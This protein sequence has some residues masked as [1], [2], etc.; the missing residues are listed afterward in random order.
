MGLGTNSAQLYE[1]VTA[2]GSS[3]RQDESTLLA[4]R[5]GVTAESLETSMGKPPE[6]RS[7]IGT[8]QRNIF[9]LDTAYVVAY[10]DG[11]DVVRVLGLISKNGA[12]IGPLDFPAGPVTLG[13]STIE[14]M[15]GPIIGEHSFTGACGARHAYMYRVVNNTPGAVN[16]R[17]FASGVTLASTTR[18][19]WQTNAGIAC[20]TE[21]D[22]PLDPDVLDSF[23]PTEQASLADA[24]SRTSADSV[25]FSSPGTQIDAAMLW[26]HPDELSVVDPWSND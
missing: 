11:S 23:S 21:L 25:F 2:P 19:S 4:L 22:D 15:T 24:F 16:Y 20:S 3:E 18:A 1:W 14:E 26:V 7:K 13:K 5:V 6:L 12:T 17:S 10:I 8:Y 9:V